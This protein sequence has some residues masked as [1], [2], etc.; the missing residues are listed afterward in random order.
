MPPDLKKQLDG[1]FSEGSMH[2]SLQLRKWLGD[3]GFEISRA[4][5]NYR[6][7]FER[8]LDSVR[9]ASEQA[10]MVCE[11]FKGD[12]DAQMHSALM[13][14]VQTRLFEVLGSRQ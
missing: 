8:R 12:D 9:L 4:I 10:R 2:S 3:N 7:N 13:R 6:Q 5:H 14:M 11:Q 1:M